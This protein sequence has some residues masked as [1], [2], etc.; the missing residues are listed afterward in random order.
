MLSGTR[1]STSQRCSTFCNSANIGKAVNTASATVTK[2]TSAST[3][4]KV[5]LPAVS[6]RWSS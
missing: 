4:V 6:A 1:L 3:D 2:G 5:K